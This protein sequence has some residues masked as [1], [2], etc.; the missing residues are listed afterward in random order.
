[1]RFSTYYLYCFH[2]SDGMGYLNFCCH[3]VATDIIYELRSWTINSTKSQAF[4]YLLQISS[5]VSLI[6]AST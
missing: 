5:N 1:M 2:Y 4:I 6:C 3:S